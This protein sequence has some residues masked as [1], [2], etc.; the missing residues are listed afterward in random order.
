MSSSA[1]E[2]RATA[3]EDVEDTFPVWAEQRVSI[4]AV[5]FTQDT[6]GVDNSARQV[7][8]KSIHKS[9]AVVYGNIF[10]IKSFV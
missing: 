10:M 4:Q 5:R 3:N 9:T 1:G 8:H 6:D 7:K 2:R